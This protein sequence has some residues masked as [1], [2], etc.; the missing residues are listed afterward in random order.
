MKRLAWL[1]G[2]AALVLTIGLGAAE[3]RGGGHHGGGGGHWHGGGHWRGGWYGGWGWGYPVYSPYYYY[4][5]PYVCGTRLIKVRRHGRY[6]WR[7]VVVRCW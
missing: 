4:G 5:A 1:A 2:F 6:V 3:A 7:R